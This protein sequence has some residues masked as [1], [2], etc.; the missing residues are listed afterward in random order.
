MFIQNKQAIIQRIVFELRYQYGYTYLDVCGHTINT[1]QKEYPVWILQ[2]GAPDPQVAPLISM[3][4][5]CIFNFSSRKLDFSIE[6]KLGGE[7]LNDK[8]SK[9]FIGQVNSLSAIVIDQ[10]GLEIFNRIGLRV[11]YLFPGKN[12]QDIEEW[13][14]KLGIY[15]INKEFETLLNCKIKS[16]GFSVVLS[17]EDKSYRLSFNGV[18]QKTQIDIGQGILN[19]NPRSLPNKQKE[20]L[21]EQMMV[22]KRLLQNPEFAAMIDIDSFI[23]NPELVEPE[24]FIKS[25]FDFHNKKIAENFKKFGG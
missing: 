4:N 1:I 19:I 24:N 25:S 14:L 7:S 20:V 17:G 21:K 11:W 8:D 15:S 3:K 23:E 2:Q 12:M 9:Y 22:K 13:L 5:G 10:L 16:T 18:E 6:K